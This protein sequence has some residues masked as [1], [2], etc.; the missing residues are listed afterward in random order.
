MVAELALDLGI[1]Q[2]QPNVRGVAVNSDL[3]QRGRREH[4]LENR[5]DQLKSDSR[6]LDRDGR[7]TRGDRVWPDKICSVVHPSR[8]RFVHGPK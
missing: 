4:V 5:G 6:R 2:R 8:Q 7:R 1:D 3:L